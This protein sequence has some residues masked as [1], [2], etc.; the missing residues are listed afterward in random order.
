MGSRIAAH[1]ANAGVPVLLLDIVPPNS[2]DRSSIAKTALER[3][4]QRLRGH[5]SVNELR[6]ALADAL[7]DPTLRIVHWRAG[8]PGQWLDERRTGARIG[9]GAKVLGDIEVGA[10]ARVGA[11][12]VALDDVPPNTTVVG[13]PAGP[14][15]D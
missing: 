9:S 2:T 3:L 11:N 6:G 7:E 12:A 1:F 13:M 4:A 5:A 8:E 15:T 14:V 10:N